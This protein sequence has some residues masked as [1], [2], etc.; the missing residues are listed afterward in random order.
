ML[1]LQNKP[2]DGGAK[3]FDKALGWRNRNV[4]AVSLDGGPEQWWEWSDW[5]ASGP[6]QPFLYGHV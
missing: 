2:H 5:L 6:D 4:V 3:Y 1:Q